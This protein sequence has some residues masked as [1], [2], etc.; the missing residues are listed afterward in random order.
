[1]SFDYREKRGLPGRMDVQLKDIAGRI[2]FLGKDYDPHADPSMWDTMTGT[3]NE[4][5]FAAWGEGAPGEFDYSQVT[6][7]I[8]VVQFFEQSPVRFDKIHVASIDNIRFD[9]PEQIVTGGMINS[10]YDSRND[11]PID[12]DSDGIADVHETGSRVFKNPEDTGTDPTNPDSDGDG[13]SDGSEVVAGTD[14]N[15]S[16]DKFEIGIDLGGSGEPVIT[17]FARTGRRYAVEVCDPPGG[18]AGLRFHSLRGTLPIEVAADGPVS[19][20]VADPGGN[21]TRLFRVL[22]WMKGSG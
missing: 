5:S 2:V 1:V 6:E 14:P 15:S 18:D 21:P 10:L 9:G 13:Q 19:F 11:S 12:S 17:W 4:L 16:L 3:V 20:T 8:C 7:L 22:V